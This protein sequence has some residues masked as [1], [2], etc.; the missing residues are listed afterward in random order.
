MKC[1]G[2][3]LALVCL[4]ARP[5]VGQTTAINNSRSNIKNN[6]AITPRADGDWQCMAAGRPC[7]VTEV[8]ALNA[9]FAGGA[10]PSA[11]GIA[12][13]S[14]VAAG[15]MRCRDRSRQPCKGSHG[16]ELSTAAASVAVRP[17]SNGRAVS[18]VGISGK[19]AV[20]AAKDSVRKPETPE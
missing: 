10:S 12:E 19:L 18:T 2:I 4:T 17:E 11:D 13:V 5:A 9:V 15:V 3:A 14:F 16:A 8:N 1:L 6:I 7:T 20:P